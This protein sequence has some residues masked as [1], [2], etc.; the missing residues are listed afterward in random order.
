MALPELPVEAFVGALEALV[1]VDAAWVPSGGEK[2]LY[3][4]PF[5]F[6][7]EVFLGVRP[8][9]EVTFCLIA[10][11]VGAV[12]RLGCQAGQDLAVRGLHQSGAGRHGCSE[13]RWQLRRKSDRA[14]GGVFTRL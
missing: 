4:R 11:P 8:A 5:M 12:L 7:S 14:A 9:K 6:A 10:S 1:R 3:L 2:S 13:M